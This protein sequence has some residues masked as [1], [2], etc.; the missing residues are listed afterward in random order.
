MTPKSGPLLDRL[1]EMRER[2]AKDAT[3]RQAALQR[4]QEQLGQLLRLIESWLAQPLSEG[5][6]RLEWSHVNV[7]DI[8][9]G[10]YVSHRMKLTFP[11]SNVVTLTPL[12]V[13]E[14]GARGLVEMACAWDKTLI[15]MDRRGIWRIREFPTSGERL[16]VLELTQDSFFR[17][18]QGALP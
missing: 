6:V 8:K 15:V 5:L 13:S 1:R 2:E 12:G 10:D 7:A 17:V 16:E 18:L 4:W 3:D 11:G 9:Y 14:M